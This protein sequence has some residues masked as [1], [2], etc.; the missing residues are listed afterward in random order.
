[1]GIAVSGPL[2]WGTPLRAKSKL[3]EGPCPG[4][5]ESVTDPSPVDLPQLTARVE[6]LHTKDGAL[7]LTPGEKLTR[8]LAETFDLAQVKTK[9][10]QFYRLLFVIFQ[11]LDPKLPKNLNFDPAQVRDI[12]LASKVFT[13][14]QVPN[15]ITEVSIDRKMSRDPSYIVQFASPLTEIPLNGKEGFYAWEEGR[16][17]FTKSLLFQSRFSF[18]LYVNRKKNLVVK[19]FQGVDMFG[20]FGSHRFVELELQYISLKRVEF[21]AG[22]KLGEIEAYISEEEFARNS[23]SPFLRL[24]SR[25]AGSKS[26]QPIDW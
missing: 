16:C 8:G 12:L 23:H 19:N 9:M 13:D 22:T 18:G 1:M 24:V 11:N 5:I 26:I 4:S 7:A 15:E 6:A 14:P 17:Q 21:F 20:D 10:E 25:F 3:A 2:L